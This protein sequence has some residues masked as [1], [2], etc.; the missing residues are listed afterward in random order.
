MV[1][2][3][4]TRLEIKLAKEYIAHCVNKGDMKEAE[5]PMYYL[6]HNKLLAEDVF[7][8]ME[9]I[10]KRLLKQLKVDYSELDLLKANT[11]RDERHHSRR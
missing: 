11:A 9:S 3:Q 7:C 10:K 5:D 1:C 2:R 6:E 4:R 8:L